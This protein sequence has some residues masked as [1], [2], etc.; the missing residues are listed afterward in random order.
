[1]NETTAGE[2][3]TDPKSARGNRMVYVVFALMIAAIGACLDLV[4]SHTN[5]AS[6]FTADS[7][8][9]QSIAQG[10]AT[11]QDKSFTFIGRLYAFL[12]LAHN[13]GL[14]GLVGFVAFVIV[15]W[16][17]VQTNYPRMADW[18]SLIA[19]VASLGFAAL[20]LGQYSKDVVELGVTAIAG[21][22]GRRQ[23]HMR[24][25]WLVTGILLIAV[26]DRTYW[27]IVLAAYLAFRWVLDRRH[28]PRR[29]L[30]E[31]LIG[32]VVLA[33]AMLVLSHH[34]LDYGRTSVNTARLGTP[35]NSLIT[36]PFGGG[37]FVAGLLN[38]LLT[39]VYLIVPIPLIF[40]GGTYMAVAVIIVLMW[41][42]V[43][44]S[45][46]RYVR[47]SQ[48]RDGVLEMSIAMA[49]GLLAV[50]AIFE[51]DYGSY[52][53]HL[54][55]LMPLIVIIPMRTRALIPSAPRAPRAPRRERRKAQA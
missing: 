10:L 37:L 49:L 54:T 9:I 33:I 43:L 15:L 55:P 24:E 32:Y 28:S 20:Y 4:F 52:V 48:V 5:I 36:E 44:S 26:L 19:I 12:G 7:E 11:Y 34:G 8:K 16:A 31:V 42:G 14:A 22:G 23:P 45:L 1:M 40:M 46:V 27:V 13:S 47:Q 21:V 51:P 50:Q 38:S 41:L 35:V 18:Q 30:L 17:V 6:R 25:F 3:V 53:R 2:T 29:I 39:A